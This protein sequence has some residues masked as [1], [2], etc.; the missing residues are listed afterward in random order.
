MRHILRALAFSLALILAIPATAVG[1]VVGIIA[2][3]PLIADF[4]PLKVDRLLLT[5]GVRQVE[6]QGMA[7][8]ASPSFYAE[9]RNHVARR[10]SEGWMVFYEEIQEEPGQQSAGMSEVLGRL[11]TEWPPSPSVQQQHPYEVMAPILD[12]GL[13]LQNNA[14][15]LGPPGPDV[16]NV[17]VTMSQLLA[18]LPSP[19]AS[20]TGAPSRSDQG[21]A[22]D[23]IEARQ[24]FDEM[25]GWA[26]DRVKAA[27]QIVLAVSASGEYAQQILPSAITSM[28]EEMVAKAIEAEEDR[29][30]LVLYGQVHVNEVVGRLIRHGAPWRLKSVGRLAAF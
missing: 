17:D 1:V 5:D 10:R 14:T 23:L 7:H 13:V 28:R 26:Q 24:M 30:I 19:T 8:L 12:D 16:R 4:V 6:L 18:A 27:L 3:L 22:I 20:R 9:I 2:A 11:G 29:N 21:A 15:L 25:P